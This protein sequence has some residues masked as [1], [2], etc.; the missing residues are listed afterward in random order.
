MQKASVSRSAHSTD[1]FGS[2][3][4]YESVWVYNLIP[5]RVSD[6]RDR[7][8]EAPTR[9]RETVKCVVYLPYGTSVVA[10]DDVVVDDR[11]LPVLDVRTDPG[12]IYTVAWCGTP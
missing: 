3:E 9:V 7:V 10:G 1:E 6:D 11:R 4:V 2:Y 12:A 5:C 8:S